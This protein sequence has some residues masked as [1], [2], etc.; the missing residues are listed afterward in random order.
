[1]S[2]HDDDPDLPLK[3]FALLCVGCFIVFMVVI[4]VLIFHY[5]PETT[6]QFNTQ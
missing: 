2:V 3:M 5:Y 4:T 6:L 1:M